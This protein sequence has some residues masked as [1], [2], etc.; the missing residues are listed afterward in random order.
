MF[1]CHILFDWNLIDSSNDRTMWQNT[2]LYDVYGIDDSSFE[3]GEVHNISHVFYNH[4]SSDIFPNCT[5]MIHLYENEQMNT[6]K[7]DKTM[8]IFWGYSLVIR[9][10]H[11]IVCTPRKEFHHLLWTLG[12]IHLFIIYLADYSLF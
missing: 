9:A 8:I 10:P 12:K 7:K 3:L 2:D 11:S 6:E 4:H 1:Q 5:R